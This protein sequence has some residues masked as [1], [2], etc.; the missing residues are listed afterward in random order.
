MPIDQTTEETDK[1]LPVPLLADSPVRH[2]GTTAVDE[3]RESNE[4]ANNAGSPEN[5]DFRGGQNSKRD[6]W[7]WKNRDRIRAK[8]A[9][10]YKQNP[11]PARLRAKKWAKD[12]RERAKATRFLYKSAR[13][14]ELS[15]KQMR[16]YYQNHFA[17]L[18]YHGL[19]REMDRDRQRAFARRKSAE[20]TDQYVREQLAKY[21][22]LSMKDFP[23][24]LVEVKRFA[25]QAR[26]QIKQKAVHLYQ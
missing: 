12:N 10:R 11:L 21:S 9:E 19:K 18:L 15:Q 14:K 6:N 17:H 2:S 16:N 26:R 4:A 13:R 22:S 24:E 7:Y 5:A 25:I 1:L 20:V 23:Q 3:A 8:A